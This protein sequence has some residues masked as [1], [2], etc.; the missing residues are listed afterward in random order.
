MSRISQYNHTIKAIEKDTPTPF[1]LSRGSD[2]S[3]QNYMLNMEVKYT[4]TTAVQTMDDFQFMEN[5][6]SNINIE[7]G[8]GVKRVDLPITEHLLLMLINRGALSCNIPKSVGTHTATI[9]LMIDMTMVKMMNPKDS[10]FRTYNYDHR[11]I[12]V[13]GGVWDMFPNVA[14]DTVSISLIETFKK[15]AKPNIQLVNDKQIDLNIMKKPILKTAPINGTETLTVDFPSKM[16]VLGALV[17]AI[18]GTSKKIKAGCIGRII[19][20]NNDA[21]KFTIEHSVK[22]QMNRIDNIFNDFDTPYFDNV[23]YFDF[24]QGEISQ[25]INT[26]DF[27]DE[28]TALQIEVKENGVNNPKLKVLFLC[29]DK[30]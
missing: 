22:N 2:L 5:L 14:V 21:Q 4:I 12:N 8:S 18:D 19:I 9:N 27:Y 29:I 17:Y 23:A 25:G 7:I 28:N 11:Y 3:A 6:I 15:G 1:P 10:L 30:A 16:R 13:I 24:A 26:A 20:D